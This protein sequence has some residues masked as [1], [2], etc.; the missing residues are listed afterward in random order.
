MHCTCPTDIGEQA[1]LLVEISDNGHGFD[2]QTVQPGLGLTSMRER[3]EYLSG[4][5]EIHSTPGPDAPGTV[6]SIQLGKASMS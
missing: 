6:V 1:T 5:L 2:E 4:T 3:A